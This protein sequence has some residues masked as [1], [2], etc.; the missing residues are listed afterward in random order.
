MIAIKDVKMPVNCE[1]CFA[2]M[3]AWCLLDEEERMVIP[4]LP[5]ESFEGRPEWC[6]LIDV[7]DMNVGNCSEIPNNSTDCI[8]RQMDL[9]D[10]KRALEEMTFSGGIE[11][12]CVLYVP[13]RD[14]NNHLKSLPSVQPEILACGSGELKVQPEV[15]EWCTDCPAYDNEKH[16]CPRFNRV[17]RE[18]VEEI[19][20]ERKSVIYYED[21]YCDGCMVYDTAECPSCGYIFDED[22]LVWKAPFCPHCGQELE[23]VGEQDE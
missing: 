7:P 4:A 22:D 14:V 12:D 17:I 8:R 2:R 11:K 3:L 13:L 23:W 20:P 6:P 21:G 9:I 15:D 18:T 16:N 5:D 19:K 10:R 1:E